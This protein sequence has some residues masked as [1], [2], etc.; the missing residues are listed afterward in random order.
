[1]L[2]NVGD[3]N[4]RN[5]SSTQS[6]S[7]V[8]ASGQGRGRS[9]GAVRSS[10]RFG[11]TRPSVPARTLPLHPHGGRGHAVATLRARKSRSDSHHGERLLD[12]P[13]YVT[14][15]RYRARPRSG[16]TLPLTCGGRTTLVTSPR[17]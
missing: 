7:H 2:R 16:L 11:P 17:T 12:S 10:R 15:H 13:A 4:V 5:A 6:G 8:R 3:F 9:S 14:P 1:M